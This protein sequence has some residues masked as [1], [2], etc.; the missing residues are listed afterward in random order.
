VADLPLDDLAADTA[1]VRVERSLG[2]DLP[3]GVKPFSGVAAATAT[4]TLA[5]PPSSLADPAVQHTAWKYSPFNPDG[6]LYGRRRVGA[7]AVVGLGFYGED[8]PE[9]L[10]QLTGYTRRLLV[11][12]PGRQATL[13]LVDRVEDFRFPVTLPMVL[14]DDRTF[15]SPAQKPGLSAAWVVDYIFRKAGYPVSPPM[16]SNCIL[17]ATLHGSGYPERGTIQEFRGANYSKLAF[18]P[19]TPGFPT[20]ARW[21]AGVQL[22]GD[23]NQQVDLATT[24][25]ASTNDGGRLFLE[26]FVRPDTISTTAS[27]VIAYRTGFSTPYV[28][29]FL[30]ANGRLQALVNRGGAWG[31]QAT[32]NA[33]PL[34][35]AVGQWHYLGCYLEFGA[36]TNCWLRVKNYTTGAVSSTGPHVLGSG[37]VTGQGPINTVSLRGKGG[38]FADDTF[39]GIVEAVQCT[40]E[41]GGG[42]PPA[43]NDGFEPTADIMGSLNE[44][45]ATPVVDGE[46][47]WGVLGQLAAAELGMVG[48]SE[49]G[50]PYYRTRRFWSTPPQ[51][52]SQETI[53]TTDKI[54]TISAEED[55][56]AVRN[57]WVLKGNPPQVGSPTTDVWLLTDI[58]SVPASGSRTIWANFDEPAAYLDTSVQS[59]ST[60]GNSRY[61][62]STAR[63]GAGSVVSNL[64]FVVTPFAQS[65]KL[66]VSNPNGF[67]V[68]LVRN[69]GVTGQQGEPQVVLAG[70]PVVF[71]PQQ[72]SG[73]PSGALINTRTRSEAQDN[74]SIA[75]YGERV[76]ELA[77]NPWLQDL[78]SMDLTA[79]EGLAMTKDP[80]PVLTGLSVVANPR[81]QLGDRVT[82]QDPDGL[83]LAGDF[84]LAAITTEQSAEGGMTQTLEVRAI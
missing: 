33:G 14:A 40:T 49:S 43:W 27:P 60:A 35:V 46:E 6:P 28:S 47:A 23:I 57:R 42:G 72:T 64:T 54:T 53:T 69:S 82:I 31:N 78:D 13:D 71:A 68:W 18:P 52:T 30:D 36:T 3:T 11:D 8:G 20:A 67:V 25:T 73:A 81:R 19:L 48:V 62:A 76:F 34:G 80:H 32:G 44:L 74:T 65:A 9:W 84:H 75:L 15:G 29:L 26:C 4:V 70:Q 21:L 16:R 41:N 37:S 7:P 39:D 56:D 17:S 66:V 45:V 59:A 61:N 10:D 24:G 38:G 58:V 2:T 51:T 79:A 12:G 55:V 83:E 5:T 22:S 50:R 63:N 1:N 77:D